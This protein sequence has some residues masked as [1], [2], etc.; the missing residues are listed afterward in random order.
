LLLETESFRGSYAER[1]GTLGVG[2]DDVV[3]P[4][5]GE[6]EPTAIPDLLKHARVIEALALEHGVKAIVVDSLSGGHALDE[7]SAEMRAVLRELSA[8]AAS[9]GVPVVVVHHL[10]KR[11]L[12][13]TAE[14]SLDRIRGSSAI[15]QFARSI[16]GLSVPDRDAGTVLVEALKSSFCARPPSLGFRISESGIE[17]VVPPEPYRV[18]GVG[19]RAVAFLRMALADGARSRVDLLALATEEGISRATF[20][21]AKEAAGVVSVDGKWTLSQPC[22]A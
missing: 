6:A 8:L 13:E 18:E 11:S 21:R 15:A 22:G 3:L 4:T 7:N 12:Y 20:D 10:R 1:L 5:L 16:L 2:N 14:V 17:F 19:E 9:V